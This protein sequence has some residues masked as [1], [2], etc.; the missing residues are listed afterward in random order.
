MNFIPG[1]GEGAILQSKLLADDRAIRIGAIQRLDYHEAIVLTHDKWK[2]DAGGISQYSFLIATAHDANNP[3]DDDEVL[4]L[5]VE[6]TAPLA[7]E[8]DLHAVREEALRTALS[9][10]ESASPSVVLDY[11][12]D[13]FTKNRASFTGLRCKVLGTFY[14]SAVDGT[15]QLIFEPDVDNFYATSTYRVLKPIGEGLSEIASYL[16]PDGEL[17]DLVTIGDVRYSATRRRAEAANQS[18]SKVTVRIQDFIGHKTALLGMTRTGKSNTATIIIARTFIA[19]QSRLKAG[20]G[21]IGQLIFDPQGEYANDNVQDG[22]AIAALGEEHVRIFKFGADGSKVHVRPLAVN[23]FD[24]NQIGTVQGLIADQ[25][26]AEGKSGYVSDFASTDFSDVPGDWSATNH[27]S[28]GRLALYAALLEAGFKPPQGFSARVSMKDA[29]ATKITQQLG[30][31]ALAS[32]GSGHVSVPAN[33]IVDV[34]KAIEELRGQKPNPDQDAADF[35]KDIRWQSAAPMATGQS[36]SSGRV[37]GFRNLIPLRDFHD[38]QVGSDVASDIYDELL[39]G[40]VVI[41]DLHIGSEKVIQTLSETI[42]VHLL[43]RQ[44]ETFTSGAEP[45]AIQ[46]MLEEAH[47]LFTTKRYND[48]A[49]VWVRLAKEAAKLKIGMIYATQEVTGVAHQVKA[50]TANWVV[51]HLNNRQE[52]N[53]LGKFYD[54]G[55]FADAILASEDR[56]FVRLK[57]LSSPFIVPV[58][59][60]KY[61]STLIAEA[62]RAAGSQDVG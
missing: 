16:R 36:T 49:D 37:R 31:G 41:V 7:L 39:T 54:F 28:R 29:L 10:T 25:L 17:S 8:S 2:F 62:R 19:S 30:Q 43:K 55:S 11:E 1:L 61:G 15:R 35:G 26:G 23:F 9:R 58:Q 13:P 56:G 60:E 51:S 18:N 50:N 40:R 3:G 57:T 4:L 33:K 6:G 24:I 34:V 59:I 12:M 5:R 45:P 21:P 32:A 46:V 44:T 27:A 42:T 14:E 52:L 48:D 38:A 53:E 22:S 47:N 20:K